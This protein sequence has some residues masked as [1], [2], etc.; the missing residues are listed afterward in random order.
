[1]QQKILIIFVAILVLLTGVTGFFTYKQGYSK[2][3][4]SGIQRGKIVG[5]DE[6]YE[7]GK[8]A[9][10]KSVSTTSGELVE[11]PLENAP[12]ANPF[13]SSTNPFEGYKNPFE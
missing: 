2:G 1:M 13:E 4:K 3:E 9:G 6:G 11:N 12:S 7:K 5:Y 8:E 10:K